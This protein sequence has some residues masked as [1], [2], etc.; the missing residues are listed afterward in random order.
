MFVRVITLTLTA[1]D[2]ER[3]KLRLACSESNFLVPQSA[4][5]KRAM[6]LRTYVL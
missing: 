3:R 2:L 4:V 5:K 6:I 1:T